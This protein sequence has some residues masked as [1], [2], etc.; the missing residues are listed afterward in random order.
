MGKLVLRIIKFVQ[1]YR[2]KENSFESSYQ[3]T[4]IYMYMYIYNDLGLY[5]Y[6]HLGLPN[7]LSSVRAGFLMGRHFVWLKVR[8]PV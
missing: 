7:L 2:N 3:Y 4:C 8:G 5:I 1:N 6:S